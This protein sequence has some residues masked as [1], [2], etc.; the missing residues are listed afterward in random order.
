MRAMV[1][2]LLSHSLLQRSQLREAQN[3]L[4]QQRQTAA[5]ADAMER[6]CADREALAA[7]MQ[8][9]MQVAGLGS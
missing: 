7:R 3:A 5:A 8:R 9:E 6:E 1:S 2:M 4:Q